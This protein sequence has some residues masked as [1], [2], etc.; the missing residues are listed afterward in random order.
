MNYVVKILGVK[1]V[2]IVDDVIVYGKG[3][4]D[5]FEKIVKVDGVNVVVC[6]VIND[7]VIDFKVI[8]I[9]IKGKKLDVI[10]Y[11]GMDVI[12]GLFVK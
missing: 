5:E 4:V 10:M 1:I 6:E 12:G 8:L 7:K 2:V 3:L 11:G 9:K